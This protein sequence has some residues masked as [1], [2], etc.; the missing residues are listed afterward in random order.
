MATIRKIRGKWQSIISKKNYPHL[1]RTF[2][3]KSTVRRWARS[4]EARM[5]RNIYEGF[6]GAMST[7]ACFF[8]SANY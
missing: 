7:N 3:D 8:N 4:V 5:D 2:Q 1:A 6:S